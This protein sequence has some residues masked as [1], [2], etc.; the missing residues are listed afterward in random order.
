LKI[1]LNVKK[2]DGLTGC[3]RL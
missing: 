2:T 3:Y 1:V